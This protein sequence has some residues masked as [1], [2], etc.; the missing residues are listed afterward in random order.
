MGLVCV[1]AALVAFSAWAAPPYVNYQ[2][3][4]LDIDSGE[5]INNPGLSMEFRIYDASSGGT[6]LWGEQHT[7]VAVT[8]GIYNVE[9]GSGATSTGVFD[10]DL[11]AGDN[12]WLEVW[13]DGEQFSPRQRCS[14][15]AFAFSTADADT[16]DGMDSTEFAESTHSH[17]GLDITGTVP[18]A[19][20]VDGQDASAF[21]PSTHGHA[22]GDLSGTATD[23]QVPDDITINYAAGAGE[24]A[25]ADMVD[26]E[27][28]S[29]FADAVHTHLG[30]DITSKVSDAD[31]LD[32]IDS[33]GFASSSHHHDS[34]YVNVTGDSMSGA[35]TSSTTGLLRV[36]N[37]TT[38]SNGNGIYATSGSYYGNAIYGESS[39]ASGNGVWGRCDG[40]YG[41]GVEGTS[42]GANSFGVYGNSSGS[43]SY[44]VRGNTSG[45]AGVYGSNSNS[46]GFGVQGYVS[47]TGGIGVVGLQ[48]SSYSP[49]DVTVWKPGGLFGGRNGVIGF[50][51]ES[52]GYG[53]YGQARG[54]STR[55]VY[56]SASGDNVYGL[57]GQASAGTGEDYPRGIYGTASGDNAYG[58]YASAYGTS[59]HGGYFYGSGT[60]A[61]GIY[62]YGSTWAADFN[63]DVRIRDGGTTV[64]TLGKGLDYAEGFDVTEYLKEEVKPGAVLVIDPVNPGKLVLST[65]A[66]DTKVAG[67]VAG[68][69][70]L[71][72]GVKLGAGQFDYDV[73]LAGRVYCNVDATDGEIKPGDMLTTS[74]IPGYAMK[75]TDHT[76]AHGAILGKAMQSLEKGQKGQI[77]VLVTLQ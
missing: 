42:T 57:Y 9:L 52:S 8:D 26:G 18:N 65:E 53:V 32:G 47:N 11:F 74:N 55:A 58:I 12:R 70:G 76:R 39:G 73:A 51:K 43:D 14:S 75:S 38:S 41:I 48:T 44:G 36:A 35:N 54:N 5:P 68:A 27:H 45:K 13:V 46:A 15:V 63:G 22:F 60:N 24:A 20:K 29:A 4:L 23:A 66:Y 50:T 6:Y 19:D 16:L 30:T 21:A 31:K 64:L 77:L 2:G 61:I 7:S 49:S 34:R 71:G 3:Q 37:T 62:A 59:S 69:N 72:S 10:P 33:S 56:G 1:M 67:I 28:A 25:N 40:K 17:D